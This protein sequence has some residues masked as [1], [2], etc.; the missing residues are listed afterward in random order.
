MIIYSRLNTCC[1]FLQTS[2]IDL[3]E[4]SV[5]KANAH[6]RKLNIWNI[7]DNHVSMN[8]RKGRYLN[9]ACYSRSNYVLPKTRKIKMITVTIV[10]LIITPI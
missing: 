7:I 1:P 3:I 6:L 9:D 5:R 2:S 8:R 10:N 4:E